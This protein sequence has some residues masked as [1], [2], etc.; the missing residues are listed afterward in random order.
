MSHRP[1]QIASV[2]HRAVQSI[3]TEGLA[4][5]RLDA[6]ITVTGVTVGADLQE[7]VVSIAV[8]PEE[9]GDLAL[10]GLRAASGFIRRK[11]GERVAL[12]RPPRLVFK[13][14]KALRK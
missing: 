14:D 12:H 4:D 2:L 13:I 9:K 10:H 7:A 8:S 5:P 6:M 11:A 3:I 1:D